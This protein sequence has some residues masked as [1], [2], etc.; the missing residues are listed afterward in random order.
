MQQFGLYYHQVFDLSKRAKAWLGAA[1]DRNILEVTYHRGKELPWLPIQYRLP[2]NAVSG[3]AGVHVK[4][5]NGWDWQLDAS[6]GY[7]TLNIED[8]SA[9]YGSSA[10]TP[11][12][13]NPVLMPS[14]VV[15]AQF[16]VGHQVTRKDRVEG[17]LFYRRILDG[18]A[19]G[20]S[21]WEGQDSVDFMGQY[22]AIQ[23]LQN[24]VQAH[25]VGIRLW[26]NMPLGKHWM[27]YGSFQTLYQ[28]TAE[29]GGEGGF[30]PAFGK[31][32]LVWTRKWLSVRGICLFSTRG[33]DN[34]YVLGWEGGGIKPGNGYMVPS[35]MVSI[36]PLKWLMLNLT[37]ENI[38]DTRYR[39]AQARFY[40][41]GRNVGGG[42]RIQF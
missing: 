9:V 40:E 27:A 21:G 7:R 42:I 39:M 36:T 16:L 19:L 4:A 37:A 34:G 17:A 33:G 22:S 1:Y 26:G 15:Q 29:V 41:P 28:Q 5:G 31:A 25:Q 32:E 14:Y 24:S 30:F 35:F 11:I 12:S 8:A 18:F 6:S 23:S 20:E 10:G 13:P 3:C 38:T 2:N